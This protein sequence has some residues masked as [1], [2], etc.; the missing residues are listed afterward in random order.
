MINCYKFRAL[1]RNLDIY[2]KTVLSARIIMKDASGLI[3]ILRCVRT[4]KE[5]AAS[6]KK[7]MSL[8]PCHDR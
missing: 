2:A 8:T 7:K 1:D 4:Q 3:P 6:F 5:E